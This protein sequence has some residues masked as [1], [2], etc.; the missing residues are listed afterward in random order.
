M[1]DAFDTLKEALCLAP[2]LVYPDY[3][4]PLIVAT[5][6]SSKAVGAVLS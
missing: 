1:Q 4:K 6:A 5:D 2:V 3:D